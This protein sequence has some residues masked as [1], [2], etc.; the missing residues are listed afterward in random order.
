MARV[1]PALTLDVNVG[2]TSNIGIGGSSTSTTPRARQAAIASKAQTQIRASAQAPPAA[3]APGGSADSA[4]T[5]ESH[6]DSDLGTGDQDYGGFSSDDDGQDAYAAATRRLRAGSGSAGA[7]ATRDNSHGGKRPRQSQQGGQQQQQRSKPS[8]RYAERDSD[9]SDDAGEYGM[10]QRSSSEGLQDEL[11]YDDDKD[12]EDDHDLDDDEDDVDVE[13]SSSP[14]IDENID[15]DLVYALHNFVAHIEGQATVHKGNH[16]TLLDDSNSYWW[17]VRVL[18]T[19]EVGY[20]PAENI[21]TPFERLARLNKHRNVD[22]TSATEDDHIQVPEKIWKSHLLKARHA[23][24]TSGLSVHSGKLSALS[25]RALGAPAPLTKEQ[26]RNKRGVVFGPSTHYEHSGN[27]YSSEEGEYDEDDIIELD[28][29]GDP[30]YE[31]EDEE[32]STDGE[33]EADAFAGMEPDDGMGWDGGEAERIQRQ[34]EVQNAA[35]DG[36]DRSVTAAE[37]GSYRQQSQQPEQTRSTHQDNVADEHG[38]SQQGTSQQRAGPAAGSQS[39]RGTGSSQPAPRGGESDPAAARQQQWQESA[40]QQQQQQQQ[41]R[42]QQQLAQQ[43]QQQQQQQQYQ[44]QQYQQQHQQKGLAPMQPEPGHARSTSGDRSISSVS[45]A[46]MPYDQA[47]GPSGSRLSTHSSNGFL[48][49][50]V[51]AHRDRSASDASAVS[52]TLSYDRPASVTSPDAKR[53]DKRKSNRRSKAGDDLSEAGSDDKS[54]KKRSGVFS[55]FSRSKDKKDRKSGSF[56]GEDRD[57]IITG[58]SSDDSFAGPGRGRASPAAAP[59]PQGYGAAPANNASFAPGQSVGMGRAVQE[60]DRAQQE[61]YQRQFLSMRPSN[62]SENVRASRD[63]LHAAG[64]RTGKPARPGSLIGPSG[65]TPMLSV[66]RVFAGQGIESES[67][68]KTV[69]LN[70]GTPSSHLLTQALQRFAVPEHERD[71]Y[72]LTIKRLEG[73]ERPLDESEF[74]LR[75]FNE[76]TEIM[77]DGRVTVPSVKRSSVGSIS[78][79][80]SNL[81]TH[82]AIA[83]LGNDFSDDHAVKFYISRKD[84]LPDYASQPPSINGDHEGSVDRND[85]SESRDSNHSASLGPA[86][87]GQ[88]GSHTSSLSADTV[89]TIQSPT[90]QFSLRL[91][92]FPADLPDGLVF[93]P[94]TTALVPRHAL[95]QRAPQY[96]EPAEGVPQDFREKILT[97]PRNTT[98]AEVVESGLD[99][100]G[101]AEGVVEGGDDVEDRPSRRKSRLHVKYGLAVEDAN[102]QRPLGPTSKILDAYSQ[103]PAFKTVSGGNNNKRKSLDASQLLGASDD[104]QST[105]PIFIL[106]QVQPSDKWKGAR[107]LSP[108]ENV[109]LAKQEERRK[110]ESQSFAAAAGTLRANGAA[111]SS[112]DHPA[113][114]AA[115]TKG[116]SRQEII[117]AQRAAA[118]ER[119]A[120]VLG[121]QRNAEQGVDVV[122]ADQGRIRSSKQ[123]D[124]GKF[125]YSYLPAEGEERDISHIIEDVLKDQRLSDSTEAARSLSPGTATRPALSKK[126]TDLTLDEYASAPS[127]PGITSPLSLEDV[128]YDLQSPPTQPMESVAPLSIG[129]N[130]ARASTKAS[131]PNLGPSGTASGSASPG[132]DLL[133]TLVR[134]PHTADSA[135]EER[136]DQVLNRVADVR[137]PSN[138][139]SPAPDSVSSGT[140]RAG[141]RTAGPSPVP[142]GGSHPSG[143]GTPTTVSGPAVS[144][145]RAAPSHRKQTSIGSEMSNSR[146]TA[147]PL[148]I[149]TGSAATHNTNTT[150]PTP[151]STLVA[152]GANGAAFAAGSSTGT[153]SRSGRSVGAVTPGSSGAD[154]RPSSLAFASSADDIGLDHLYT[155]VDAAARRDPRRLHLLTHGSTSSI[156]GDINGRPSTRLA[157]RLLAD[158][159]HES[160]RPEAGGL[161]APQMPFVEHQKT[162][163]AYGSI[164][165]QLGTIDETL[166]QI[167]LDVMR[168]F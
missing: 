131:T 69:L 128:H 86:R 133:E 45:S 148:T 32:M 84:R 134:N 158:T 46:G 114:G 14:S 100:F 125:R 167:L 168:V 130:K 61:A 164:S 166:D 29:N 159:E 27:E 105:D 64:S 37:D 77:S 3:A 104:I 163:E 20:I 76:L 153:G 124:T 98:V 145:S 33:A 9:S 57:S 149:G 94:Q 99:R 49:S 34:Q 59:T 71:K 137:P 42:Q 12:D 38:R 81:S 62:D 78:S 72:V 126:S 21:E 160:L 65:S 136:I 112:S 165:T 161:F 106:R 52:N 103:P 28:E 31:Y 121:A 30:I 50:Q 95:E 13:L 109:L 41:E 101:I 90:A 36:E 66:M 142:I 53:D 132:G 146:D 1:K 129:G 44:Q 87:H 24:G 116:M 122:L 138:S 18:R 40:Q 75:L 55:L 151:M 7:R 43:Q 157:H 67:T 135:I 48:P 39:Q 143:R 6:L 10:R 96:R 111:S 102:G 108:T 2:P 141:S 60:R 22:L 51:Q 117:A 115:E 156:S 17:L 92:V 11:M 120:A 15:F 73:S 91:V 80:S 144:G 74:P 118:H 152:G 8:D 107:S 19:Q 88:R 155:I 113:L 119:R 83:R 4:Y 35:Q 162:R 63:A 54:A 47:A 85:H 82:P 93:D 58:R 150:M 123:R 68:F 147:S 79:I 89:E 97:F 5:V 154:G 139:R 26:K 110:M 127:S 70:E 23:T 56:G 140:A 25:R 16:L